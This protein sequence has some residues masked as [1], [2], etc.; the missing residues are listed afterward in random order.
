MKILPRLVTLKIIATVMFILSTACSI[1]FGTGFVYAV[2]G[3]YFEYPQE[4][5]YL[6]SLQLKETMED[7]LRDAVNNVGKKDVFAYLTKDSNLIYTITNGEKIEFISSTHDTFND[8]RIEHPLPDGRIISAALKNPPTKKDVFYYDYNLYGFI[9]SAR[10]SFCIVTVSC[11]ATSLFLAYFL[12]CG[13]G[14]K[15]KSDKIYLNMADNLPL[16]L[17]A[18][19]LILGMFLTG[20][21]AFRLLKELAFWTLFVIVPCLLIISAL[22]AALLDTTA[23]RVKNGTWWK[24]TL[25]R[26]FCKFIWQLVCHAISDVEKVFVSLTLVWRTLIGSLAYL[27]ITI[28]AINSGSGVVTVI[29]L[30]ASIAVIIAI[31]LGVISADKIR[32]GAKK[33]ANGDLNYKIETDDIFFA[34]KN[35]AEDLNSISDVLTKA[36]DERTKSEKFKAELITN[37]SHDIKTPITSIINYVDLLGRDNLTEEQR[38]QY[39][40]VLKRQSDRLKKLTVDLVEA[41]KASTGNISVKLEPLD[42]YEMLK[43]STGEFSERISSAGLQLELEL[44][45]SPMTILADGRLLWRVFE[46]LLSNICKYSLPGTRVYVTAKIENGFAV[47][48]FK[49]IS[50]DRLSV[51]GQD[52]AERFVRGDSAR[53]TEGSGLGLSIAKSFTELQKG[54]FDITV[55][56]DLF[57]AEIKFPL[58]STNNE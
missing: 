51:S 22:T 58:R 42:V 20:F 21:L 50:R 24:D 31:C 10:Y 54:V 1:A 15:R 19:I 26:K 14:R 32:Q 47:T 40:D 46:N 18:F 41:S 17:Y 29:W 27:T 8:T 48:D 6:Q 56:G 36:V 25:F 2:V 7:R 9:Y 45:E 16:D 53:S 38:N 11:L 4:D 35:H 55:D 37:V 49:N 44:A 13:A 52:L 30:V 57:K 33:L 3:G 5:D 28:I 43:Q 39:L 23:K 12:M 34:F